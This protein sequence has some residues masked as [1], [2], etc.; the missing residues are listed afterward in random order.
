M[1]VCLC[2]CLSVCLC[3]CVSVY[4]ITK[5]NNG[6]I[7]LKLEHAVVYG[8]SSDEFGIGHCMIKVKVTA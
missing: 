4:T 3:V 2:W 8:N 1:S 7:N 5:K 6:L